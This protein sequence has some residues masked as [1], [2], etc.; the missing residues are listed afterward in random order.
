VEAIEKGCSCKRFAEVVHMNS[1]SCS[2]PH[3]PKKKNHQ[4]HI[5]LKNHIQ[6]RYKKS[7]NSSHRIAFYEGRWCVIRGGKAKEW[8]GLQAAARAKNARDGCRSAPVAANSHTAAGVA[9]SAV[10]Y[11]SA[12]GGA[13]MATDGNPQRWHE[14][15]AISGYN[16]TPGGTRVD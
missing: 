9:A 5:A 12:A 3:P 1:L 6:S 8:W 16:G 7:F 15:I 2:S 13:N 10:T 14:M 4:Q 11:T